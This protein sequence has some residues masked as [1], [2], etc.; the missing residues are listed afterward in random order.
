MLNTRR[1]QRRAPIAV[2]T[3]PLSGSLMRTVSRNRVIVLIGCICAQES[4]DGC[5]AI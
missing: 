5:D 1:L 2:Y 3:S 4:I